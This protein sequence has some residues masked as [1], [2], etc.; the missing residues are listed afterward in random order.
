MSE[1]KEI[2]APVE[3]KEEEEE[4][5]KEVFIMTIPEGESLMID[6][7]HH[8]YYN[9]YLMRAERKTTK[10]K[11][12]LSIKYKFLP[13]NFDELTEEQQNTVE[14]VDK[15][16][17]VDFDDG[18][19]EKELEFTFVN[20]CDATLEAIGSEITVEGVFQED[21]EEEDPYEE[22]YEEEKNE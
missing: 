4:L 22:E 20:D 18:E 7:E 17:H 1:N 15:E 16:D 9:C 2:A 21:P 5:H 3:Q 10:G 6:F 19:K 11:A 14:M 13:D 12:K 8:E